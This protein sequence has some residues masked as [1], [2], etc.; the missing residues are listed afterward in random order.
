VTGLQVH[1]GQGVEPNTTLVTILPNS[2]TMEANLFVDSSAIGFVRVEEPVLLRYAAFPYQKFGLYKGKVT[3][4]TRAP[5]TQDPGSPSASGKASLYRIV[6]VPELPYILADG[7]PQ[8]L[9][10]GMQVQATIALDRRH[11]YEWI[12][13]PFYQVKQSV[14][15]ITGADAP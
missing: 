8:R 3:E 13:E 2:G 6:V 15:I 9:E 10:A 5:I 12:F 14:R 7:K 4:I 11:L 1:I